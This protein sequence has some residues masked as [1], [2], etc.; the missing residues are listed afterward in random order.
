MI[1]RPPRS[2]LFPYTTLF[3]SPGV[4]GRERLEA[5]TERLHRPRPEVL[6]EHVAPAHEGLQHLG[7]LRRLEVERNVAFV[8][9]D[10]KVRRRLAPLVGRPRARL[11][12]GAR[13]LHLDHV[14]AQVR[15]QHAAEVSGQEARAID[16]TDAVEREGR[17]R[18]VR[19]YTSMSP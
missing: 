6:D 5:Q 4:D 14:G 1:R 9:V 12:A 3:R 17:D 8:A 2:T 19:Y 7:A 11:V 16:D 15:E 10:D 18:H 13:V